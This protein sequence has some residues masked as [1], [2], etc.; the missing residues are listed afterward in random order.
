MSPTRSACASTAAWSS[1]STT[2]TSAS[3]MSAATASRVCRVR[4]TRW[5]RA[6]CSAKA[7]AT[8][9]PMEP[10]APYTIAVLSVSSMVS[11]SEVVRT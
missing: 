1:A 10:P 11:S 2:A 8:A 4:P 3:L 5:T 6:P 9:P 7:R